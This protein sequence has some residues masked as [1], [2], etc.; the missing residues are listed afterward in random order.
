MSDRKI[1]DNINTLTVDFKAKMKDQLGV[2]GKLKDMGDTLKELTDDDDPIQE[3][4]IGT[5][6]A[7]EGIAEITKSMENLTIPKV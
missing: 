6:K 1:L 3:S 5:I 2:L 4:I 7:I